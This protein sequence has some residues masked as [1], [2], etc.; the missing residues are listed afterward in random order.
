MPDDTLIYVPI[1]DLAEVLNT[2][3][4]TLR[5][6]VKTGVIPKSTYIKAANTY[7]FCVPQ[8]LAALQGEPPVDVE[9]IGLASDQNFDFDINID[10][11][12]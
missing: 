7:R 11:D 5:S 8:V 12:V 6:W 9:P 10:E 4:T 1:K 3:V 2:K